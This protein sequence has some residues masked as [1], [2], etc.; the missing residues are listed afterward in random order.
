MGLLMK[1]C[2]VCGRRSLGLNCAPL[3]DGRFLCADCD[4]AVR[5]YVKEATGRLFA[6]PA[7]TFDLETLC[8]IVAGD[9]PDLSLPGD[10]AVDDAFAATGAV[11]TFAR[12]NDRARELLI[13]PVRDVTGM[14]VIEGGEVVRYDDI[15]AAEVVDDGA[16]VPADRA[17]RCSSLAL[18]LRLRDGSQRAIPVISTPQ[19]RRGFAYAHGV[20][21]ARFLEAHLTE[22]R[23]KPRRTSD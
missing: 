22:A 12:Y 15:V 2:A 16:P 3:R 1:G 19:S 14:E 4:R 5:R 6:P 18:R 23:T 11:G 20:E 10:D 7:R 8:A 17:G 21:Q 13:C 9:A